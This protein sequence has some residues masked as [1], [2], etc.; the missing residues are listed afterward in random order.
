MNW[1]GCSIVTE[2]EIHGTRCRSKEKKSNSN[3]FLERSTKQMKLSRYL[4]PCAYKEVEFLAR[5]EN[6][7]YSGLI[8]R[9]SQRPTRE[10]DAWE[11]QV[12]PSS[13]FKSDLNHWSG[14]GNKKEISRGK[15]QVPILITEVP[16]FQFYVILD[17]SVL[18]WI[19]Q[20]IQIRKIMKDYCCFRVSF[21][22]RAAFQ[23]WP[24]RW[25][26]GG[27][28]QEEWMKFCLGELRCAYQPKKCIHQSSW[29]VLQAA[30]LP[31]FI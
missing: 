22:K 3:R 30:S 6:I 13:W 25:E 2:V 8:T 12:K 18:L 9:Y 1:S 4:L 29:K 14:Y 24:T 16:R 5:T 10:P 19:Y 31:Q 7:A 15:N 17:R 11:M 28:P 20:K 21:P 27:C 23:G 26:R